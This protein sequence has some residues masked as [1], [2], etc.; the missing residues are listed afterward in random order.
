[1]EIVSKTGL[2]DEILIDKGTSFVEELCGQMCE[3]LEDPCY[4]H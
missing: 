3:L 4:L 1:M 2:P